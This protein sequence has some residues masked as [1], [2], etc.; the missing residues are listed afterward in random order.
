MTRM[1]FLRI[2]CA[3]AAVLALAGCAT[4]YQYR[5]VASGGDYYLAD[6][7]ATPYYLA[8]YGTLGYGWPGGWY[9]NV[10]LGFGGYYGLGGFYRPY[11]YVPGAWYGPPRYGYRW[12]YHYRPRPRHPAPKMVERPHERRVLPPREHRRDGSRRPQLRRDHPRYR[13]Q[14]ALVAAGEDGV[15]ES[16]WRNRMDGNR[17]HRAVPAASGIQWTRPAQTVPRR[18][19]RPGASAPPPRQLRAVSPAAGVPSPAPARPP[20]MLPAP[21]PAAT[22]SAPRPVQAPSAPKPAAVS[23]PRP[24]RTAPPPPPRRAAMPAAPRGPVRTNQ[25][26]SER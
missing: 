14:D 26:I 10:G 18:E 22:P 24:L 21:R 20:R 11:G 1:M 25:R 4:G 16:G 9:G 15:P 13:R 23:T 8:P 2:G 12:P 17:P 7:V 3:L 19:L 5:A 6:E